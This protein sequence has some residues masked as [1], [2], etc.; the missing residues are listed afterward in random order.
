M[1]ETQEQSDVRQ[2]RT[3]NTLGSK[4]QQDLTRRALRM[5]ER[6]R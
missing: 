4:D 6:L 1:A 2:D 5:L 3:V